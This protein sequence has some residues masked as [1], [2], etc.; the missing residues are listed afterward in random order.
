MEDL[1]EAA[2]E[3]AREGNMGQ[4]AGKYGKPETSIKDGEGKPISNRLSKILN[5]CLL[6]IISNCL[7]WERTNHVRAEEEIKKTLKVHRTY[8]TEI[9]KLLHEASPNLKSCS[10]TKRGIPKYTLV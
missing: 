8:T 4:L 3:A 6:K 5:I 9:I 2:E 7:L 10:G 1:A